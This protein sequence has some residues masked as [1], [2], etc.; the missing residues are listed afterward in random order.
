MEASSLE[1]KPKFV[2]DYKIIEDKSIFGKQEYYVL[3]CE[4]KEKYIKIPKNK[5]KYVQKIIKLFDGSSTLSNVQS[6]VED[7]LKCKVDIDAF[8]K[9]L[10]NNGFIENEQR[11]II[12]N[13][14][15][16]MSKE[17]VKVILKPQSKKIKGIAKAIKKLFIA[18]Y[19]IL[20]FFSII[21][22]IKNFNVLNLGNTKQLYKYNNSASAG[23]IYLTIMSGFSLIAHELSHII[24]ALSLGKDVYK[25]S[26]NLY[27][28]CMPIVYI[29]VKGI[30]TLKNVEKIQIV[31]AGL[32]TN[33]AIAFVSL[34]I[35]SLGGIDSSFRDM[36]KIVAI[37]N[38][39]A[40]VTNL[41]P[42]SLTDG[43][44]LFSILLNKFNV[45]TYIIKYMF[46]KNKAYKISKKERR[47]Y[48]IYFIASLIAIAYMFLFMARW[49]FLAW[50]DAHSIF[51]KIFVA[52]VTV[53]PCIG[54]V[55]ILKKLKGVKNKQQ[56]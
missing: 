7:E 42:F 3:A 28:G 24:V 10:V 13:E 36:C 9:I 50:Y 56:A 40:I 43:Y 18:L 31:M 46:F 44:F 4:D 11:G 21:V 5:L 17:I 25:V 15:D 27:S 23:F 51:T 37:S 8:Y 33:L 38:F 49:I 26:F 6:K 14:I 1:A 53:L 19:S 48:F 22:A 52:I 34:G 29:K 32:V 45:R 41:S 47:V 54:I 30:N 35:A 2:S 55:D 12:S 16:I 39:I 20:I